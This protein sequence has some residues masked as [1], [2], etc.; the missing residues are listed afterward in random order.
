MNPH[1]M[2][3]APQ[4]AEWYAQQLLLTKT[5]RCLPRPL[6]VLDCMCMIRFALP[7]SGDLY[8]YP[9]MFP[10]EQQAAFVAN[11]ERDCT[12][13]ATSMTTAWEFAGHWLHAIK[14]YFPRYATRGA[15]TCL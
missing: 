14:E 6:E 1:V 2:H 13:L 4:W 15:S 9:S 8:A 11:T 5:D 12:L 3:L 10:E 7:P